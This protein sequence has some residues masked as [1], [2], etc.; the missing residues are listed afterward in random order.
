MPLFF[1]RRITQNFNINLN[2]ALIV[3]HRI[4]LSLNTEMQ[5]DLDFEIKLN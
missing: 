1:V 5:L 2:P 3:I 4:A